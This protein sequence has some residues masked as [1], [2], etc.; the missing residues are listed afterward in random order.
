MLHCAP[1]VA[2]SLLAAVAASPAP[3]PSTRVEGLAREVT[4]LFEK[5]DFDG[6]IARFSPQMGAALPGT[7]FRA[8]WDSLPEQLGRAGSRP[9]RPS[10]GSRRRGE[11]L[12]AGH[13]REGRRLACG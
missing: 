6:V 4:A 13:V 8:V 5:G 3:A 11:R 1:T 10:S 12:G 9:G 7:K 2:F